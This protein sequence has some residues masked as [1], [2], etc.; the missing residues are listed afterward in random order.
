MDVGANFKYDRFFSDLK[1]RVEHL[2]ANR[3]ELAKRL[4]D[5]IGTFTDNALHNGA[6]L[7]TLLSSK[8]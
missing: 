4:N 1:W 8:K 3:N 2:W 5:R 7:N 6:L